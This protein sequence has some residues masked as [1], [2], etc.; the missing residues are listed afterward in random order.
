[1]GSSG[2]PVINTQGQ[3]CVVVYAITDTQKEGQD[4]RYSL[5]IPT[6]VLKAANNA[7]I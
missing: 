7:G 3:A 5:A 6:E 2:S 1:M 4:I